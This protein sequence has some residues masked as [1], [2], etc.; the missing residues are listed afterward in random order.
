MSKHPAPQQKIPIYS[1]LDEVV[2]RLSHTH[3]LLAFY[4]WLLLLGLTQIEAHHGREEQS[5][6]ELHETTGWAPAASEFGGV[7]LRYEMASPFPHKHEH[8]LHRSV[9]YRL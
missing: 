4:H 8:V 7:D 5:I 6:K 3:F 1:C 2:I 9:L